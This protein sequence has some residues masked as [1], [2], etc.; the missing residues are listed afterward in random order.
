MNT[1][2]LNKKSNNLIIFMLGWGM[3]ERPLRPLFKTKSSSDILFLYDYSKINDFAF[4]TDFNKYKNITLVAFSCGV[5]MASLLKEKFPK[6]NLKIAING[7]LNLFDESKG[8]PK[9]SLEVMHNMSQGN[10]ME[11]REKYLVASKAEL[12]LF[13]KNQPFRNFENSFCELNMLQEYFKKHNEGYIEYDYVIISENDRILPTEN[14]I[15]FWKSAK[16][17]Y[18]IVKGGHFPFYN[19]ESIES[20]VDCATQPI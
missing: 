20:L 1:F 18:K 5:Y 7:T 4:T 6:V 19:F 17:P 12:D 8:V 14:Q 10:Y 15:R 11:F 13:N 16:T 9:K 2:F 3:D